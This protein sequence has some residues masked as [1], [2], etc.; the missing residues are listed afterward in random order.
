MELP[1]CSDKLGLDRERYNVSSLSTKPTEH[2]K[3]RAAREANPSNLVSSNL[4]TG[5]LSEEDLYC[6]WNKRERR[7][8][9]LISL[10]ALILFCSIFGS[11]HIAA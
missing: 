1:F 4:Y 6:I 11:I 3:R 5:S 10:A 7:R 8:D 9:D 2:L